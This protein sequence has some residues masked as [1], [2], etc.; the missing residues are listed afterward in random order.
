[1]MYWTTLL[2][3]EVTEGGGLFDL[4][5]TLPLMAIQFM[6]LVAIL[7]VLFYKPIG[8]AI[9]DRDGYVSTNLAE[10]QERLA[11]ANKLA[12][13][14]EEELAVA[15]RKTQEIITSA[16][17]EASE[18]ASSKIAVAQRAAQERREAAQ[19]DLDQQKQQA[20]SALD[21]Q[22]DALSRQIVAKL[23]GA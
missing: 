22:V 12:D 15:R 10:A 1:M 7:N 13:Q 5:A 6:V 9:D 21:Q 3:A 16:Q 4:D 20:M 14:Y 23:I 18:I 19:A 8:K 17:Q 2:A 11:K